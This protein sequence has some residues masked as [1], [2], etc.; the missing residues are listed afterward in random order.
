M[1]IKLHA[2]LL[3]LFFPLVYAYFSFWGAVAFLLTGLLLDSDHFLW[4]LLKFRE[5]NPSKA[6]S[7]FKKAFYSDKIYEKHAVLGIFHTIEFYIVF[8]LLTYNFRILLPIFLGLSLHMAVDITGDV[9][10]YYNK[11]KIRPYS[12]LMHVLKNF[13]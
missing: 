2:L 11:Q 1:S 6:F 13:F 3:V 7:G 4:Y 10:R 12:I 9:K 5:K 8:A